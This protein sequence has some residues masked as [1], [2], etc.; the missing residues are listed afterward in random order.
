MARHP[1]ICVV[2]G[3]ALC[4][5]GCGASG[6]HQSSPTKRDRVGGVEVLAGSLAHFN[7]G[8]GPA[9]TA[10]AYVHTTGYIAAQGLPLHTAAQAL[11]NDIV[12]RSA[13][14]PRLSATVTSESGQPFASVSVS[15][16]RGRAAHQTPAAEQAQQWVD[17]VVSGDIAEV[18]VDRRLPAL[19]TWIGDDGSGGPIDIVAGQRFSTTSD[20]HIFQRIHSIVTRAGLTLV[21]VR[22]I[23]AG[24]PA[25]AVIV[26]SSHPVQA[27]KGSHA[28]IN[29]L[30][31]ARTPVYEG[32]FYEIENAHGQPV[33]ATSVSFRTGLG[34]QWVSPRY[35]AEYPFDHG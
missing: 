14:G 30:F 9:G 18:F 3:L 10:T 7:L 4:I 2:L 29:R 24:E 11:A 19:S 31:G 27:L 28:V 6:R 34:S 23:R 1:V 17:S 15:D 8:G 12:R 32:D 25:P 5:G 20:A 21:S 35:E 22:V 26:K 16:S 33:L 13:A